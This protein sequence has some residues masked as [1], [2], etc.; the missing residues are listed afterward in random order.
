MLLQTMVNVA[1]NIILYPASVLYTPPEVSQEVDHI[2]FDFLWPNKKHHVKKKVLIQSI[3]DGGLKMPCFYT[4]LKANKLTW[5]KR[6]ISKDNNFTSIA[7]AN[8]RIDNFSLFFKYKMSPAHMKIKPTA[9]YTQI[10]EYWNELRHV[11]K[12]TCNEILNEPLWLNKDIIIGKY[13]VHYTDWENHGISILNDIINNDGTFKSSHDLFLQY[14]LKVDIMKHNSIKSSISRQ[15]I[16]TIQEAN[17]TIFKAIERGSI[18][19]GNRYKKI[20]HIKC[21]EFYWQ[22]ISYNYD[23]PTAIGK[24]EEQYYYANFKWDDIFMLTYTTSIETSLQSLQYRIINRFIA[25]N[26]NLSKR[27]KEQDKKL[28]NL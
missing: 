13:P 2:F 17:N 26:S 3:A 12:L 5:I 21:K 27:N 4:I 18:K 20:E 23:R 10:I 11:G 19:I 1:N 16:K 7:H 14:N 6:L 25:C 8:A 28:H 24:W 22:I 9:F 15:W